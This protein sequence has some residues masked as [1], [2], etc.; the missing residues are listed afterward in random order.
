MGE[1]IVT[2]RRSHMTNKLMF[3]FLLQ[4]PT[5]VTLLMFPILVIMYLWL[6]RRE[7]QDVRTKFGE[8]YCHYADITPTFFP[9]LRAVSGRLSRDQ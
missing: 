8:A 6:A 7:E 1:E 2:R 3:G 4:W 5:L 9:H